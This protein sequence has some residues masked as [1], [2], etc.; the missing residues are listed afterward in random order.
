[1]ILP[2][3]REIELSS[4]MALTAATPFRTAGPL[5]PAFLPGAVPWVS[6]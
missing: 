5:Q 3:R 2:F 4:L 1:V 6:V